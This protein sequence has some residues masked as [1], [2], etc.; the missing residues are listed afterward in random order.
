M[1][2]SY[3]MLLGDTEAI[4]DYHYGAIPYLAYTDRREMDKSTGVIEGSYLGR[5]QQELVSDTIIG[6]SVITNCIPRSQCCFTQ[7]ESRDVILGM[8]IS[9]PS[10]QRQQ[11]T[12][13]EKQTNKHSQLTATTTCIVIVHGDD[14]I[15]SSWYHSG[16]L[17][18]YANHV[19]IFI[20]HDL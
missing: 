4:Q 15:T 11:I 14:I 3:V 6:Y 12:E 2:C 13:I 16:A 5:L 7:S 20:S 9:A 1:Y 8:E 19:I 17:T 18:R 10:Q